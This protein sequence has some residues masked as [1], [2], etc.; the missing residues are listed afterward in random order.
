MIEKAR[1]A[2]NEQM[3]GELNPVMAERVRSILAF[4][5]GLG[6][7]PRIQCAWRSEKEQIAKMK[8]GN[9]KLPWGM[10]CATTP[11]GKPDSLAVDVI[12]DDDPL[13]SDTDRTYLLQVAAAARQ[14]KC[15]SGVLWG[16]PPAMQGPTNAAIEKR[17]WKAQVRIGWD[18]CHVQAADVTV[19]QAKAG[20]RPSAP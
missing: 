20:K 3:L 4:L 15:V 12:D 8:A 6:R 1:K 5:E 11:Q 14:A 10:H 19:A 17:D 2:R 13:E 9:S 16:I 18:P 7:R